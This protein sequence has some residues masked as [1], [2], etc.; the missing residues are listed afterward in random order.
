MIC[1]RT[2]GTAGVP[3]LTTL[4]SPGARERSGENVD[5]GLAV[6]AARAAGTESSVPGP[7]P[8]SERSR[9]R[10]LACEQSVRDRNL[11]PSR[12]AELLTEDVTVR[13]RGPG[14]DAKSLSDLVVREACS[15]QFDD[16]ALPLRQLGC[17]A[18]QDLVHGADANSA[19]SP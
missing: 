17:C 8:E 10:V 15:D 6:P 4:T 2:A 19:E 7:G 18:S 11:A 1:R 9:K 13:L 5:L 14:R 16:L 12:D 3:P